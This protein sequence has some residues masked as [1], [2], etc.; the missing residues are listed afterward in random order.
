MALTST[1]NGALL[2][3]L[4]RQRPLWVSLITGHHE[5]RLFVHIF[6][7]KKINCEKK[8]THLQISKQVEHKILHVIVEIQ[9]YQ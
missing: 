6:F 4:S 9:Y 1:W 8:K 5:A 3:M 7:L 2:M